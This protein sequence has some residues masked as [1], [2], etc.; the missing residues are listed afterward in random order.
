MVERRQ[1]PPQIKR[2]ELAQRDG[3]RAV[4]RYQLTVDV[5]V[6]DGSARAAQALRAEREARAALDA[7]R[8]DVAKGTYVHPGQGDACPSVRGLARCQTR[9]QTVDAAWA[10]G[11]PRGGAR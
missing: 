1:L 6:V 10:S 7:V 8:G 4:I 5:G 9:P 2:V 3:S 11:E